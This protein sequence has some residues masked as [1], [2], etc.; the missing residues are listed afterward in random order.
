[1]DMPGRVLHVEGYEGKFVALDMST[2]E[3]VASADDAPSLARLL[4]SLG[5]RNVMTVGVPA[6]DE[7]LRVGLG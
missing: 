4:R 2:Y 5:L 7:P 3:V 6:L 1:L